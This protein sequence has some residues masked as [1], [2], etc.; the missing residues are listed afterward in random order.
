MRSCALAQGTATAG[1]GRWPLAPVAASPHAN[2]SRPANGHSGPYSAH[3][4]R[5]RI[6]TDTS[7]AICPFSA[8]FRR[9]SANSVSCVR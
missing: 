1:A 6:L 4:G 3:F 9:K 2:R 8:E 5:C 7:A